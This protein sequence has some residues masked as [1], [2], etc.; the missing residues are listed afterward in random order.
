MN[1]AAIMTLE[2]KGFTNPLAGAQSA[3]SGL[4]AK[5]GP[6]AIALAGVAAAGAVA[7]G[8]FFGL[9]KAIS[10]AADME[11]METSFSVLLGSMDAA[12]ARMAELSQFAAAT[13]FEL[14]EIAAASRTLQ[15]L[16]KGAM[17]TGDGLTLIGDAAAGTQQPFQEMANTVGKA[18]AALNNGGAAGEALNRLVELGVVSFEAKTKIEALQ[19]SGQKGAAVWGIVAQSMGQFSG[20]MKQQSGTWNGLMSTLQDS[21]NGVFRAFG[22]PLLD[23]LK[24]ILGDTIIMTDQ[25]CA[26]ATQWGQAMADSITFAR[27]LFADGKM[28]ETA[29]LAL[30][31]GFADAVNYLAK[32]LNELWDATAKMVSGSGD[33]ILSGLITAFDG[34]G[35]MISASIKRAFVDGLK[36]VSVLGIDVLSDKNAKAINASASMDDLN[37]ELQFKESGAQIKAGIGKGFI[38]GLIGGLNTDLVEARLKLKETVKK[39]MPTRGPEFEGPPVPARGEPE[40]AAVVKS[41]NGNAPQ[42]DR[43]AKIGLFVGGGGPANEHAR[44]TAD[45]TAKQLVLT[46]RVIKALGKL[47]PDNDQRFAAFA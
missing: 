13:P 36:D 3:M 23:A 32:K 19:A 41:K 25:L 29:G 7:G 15:T 45:H 9:K 24:P 33:G 39:Y 37:A 12:K 40:G 34:I 30:R 11:T 28:G 10:E 16:T 35:S 27:N 1:L 31:V 5:M 47:V 46:E 42:G 22:T 26:K 18:Y 21:I 43:L 14:P 20:M 17:A 4:M 6:A 44:K 8:A 38:G 2:T